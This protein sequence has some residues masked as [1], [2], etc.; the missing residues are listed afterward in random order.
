MTALIGAFVVATAFLTATLSGVFGMAGGL[1][2]M[3][4]LALVLPVS[5]AFVTHGLLQL[6]ANG[7]RAILHR[8]H[9]EW[10]IVAVYA[11]GSLAAAGVVALVALQP[12][13]P[14]LYLLLGLVPGLVW[15]PQG[16]LKLDAA[17]PRQAFVSGLG[18]T[19]LNLTAGVAGPLLD[20]FFVRTALT[21]HAIVAT[22]AA[23][24]VFS[25]LMKIV[26]YGA[27]LLA[28]GGKGLPPPWVFGLAVPLSMAGTAVGG[29]ILDR[30]S[31]VNFKRWLRWIVT[32]IGATYLVQAAQLFLAA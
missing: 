8:R 7:W 19:G 1:V 2:L 30:M 26:I 16:W 21:R 3:G 13:K 5:A 12:S 31:D 18:V 32:V 10:R 28:T 24:Q 17:D 23:T 11:A 4:A 15:I 27:P 29:L 22:K 9:V 25:H 20:I 6:V 14:L